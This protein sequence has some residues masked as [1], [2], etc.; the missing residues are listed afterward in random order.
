MLRSKG[1]LDV[2]D[3]L[4]AVRGI[5]VD[6]AHRPIGAKPHERSPVREERKQ[7]VSRG[8]C[9]QW[10]LVGRPIGDIPLKGRSNRVSVLG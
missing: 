7:S 8:Q 4:R 9:P 1:A 6:P 3:Q 10:S 2:L 5:K